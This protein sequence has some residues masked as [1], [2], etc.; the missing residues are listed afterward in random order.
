MLIKMKALFLFDQQFIIITRFAK[1]RTAI[2]KG[3]KIKSIS[4]KDR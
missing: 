1:E 2:K 4:F 3:N